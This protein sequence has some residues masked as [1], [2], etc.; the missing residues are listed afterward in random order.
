M[1]TTFKRIA[2]FIIALVLSL[3]LAATTALAAYKTIPYGEQSDAVR[4][5][6][7]SLKSKGYY[8]GMVDG[9][10]G[11]A[12][13]SAVIKFQQAVGITADGKPGNKT[14]TAL[15]E[16]RSAINKAD[17]T[18]QKQLT[19][20]TNPRSLY[21]GC[22][23]SRVRTLQR[24]LKAAGVYKGSIDGV[25][26][27][28]TYEAVLKY[29]RMKGLHADGIAGVK[30]QASLKKNTGIQVY[31]GMVLAY[32]SKGNEVKALRYYLLSQGYTNVG[33]GDLFDKTLENAVKDWQRT[34]NKPVTG[35]ITESQY[36]AMIV[37]NP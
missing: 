20:V 26:G 25:Y 4:K 8:K 11:P 23:G 17:N 15:Y 32:G 30:T 28:L 24:A 6:Q 18:Q 37:G 33:K 9:K 19:K 12:T 10:F 2:A 22:T 1:N 16:G 31:G 3:S 36:N 29:Q 35:Q 13:K 7:T 14:L 21:Y 5:M 27:D 34:N